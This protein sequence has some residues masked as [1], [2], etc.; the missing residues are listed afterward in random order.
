MFSLN[1]WLAGVCLAISVSGNGPSCVAE[2]PTADLLER[3]ASAEERGEPEEAIRLATQAIEQDASLAAG[4]KIRA[5]A[6]FCAGRI[7]ESMD[8]FD[9][10]VKR[11]PSVASSQWERGIACY[12]AGKFQ[13]GVKQFESYQKVDGQ[14]VENSVWRYLCMVPEVGVQRAEAAMLPIESDRRVPM[15]QVFEMFRGRLKPE[16]VLSA[17]RAGNPDPMAL[18]GQMFYANLYLGLWYEAQGDKMRARR[19]IELAADERLKGNNRIN[20]YMWRVAR[21]HR[22]LLS[23]ELKLDEAGK[24]R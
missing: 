11:R 23:G 24:G 12:Y 2:T 6:R 9:E 3:A 17:A 20:G 15:M 10:Y 7:R 22:R 18:D 4:Y 13:D 16:E 1:R 19:Y 8:D 21:I 14:D 5:R